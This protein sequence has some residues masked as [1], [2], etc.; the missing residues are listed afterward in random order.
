MFPCCLTEILYPAEVTQQLLCTCDSVGDCSLFKIPL[1]QWN[2]ILNAILGY[3]FTSLGTHKKK[4]LCV[5]CFF[6]ALIHADSAFWDNLP[7][8]FTYLL[9]LIWSSVFNCQSPFLFLLAVICFYFTLHFPLL[10][11]R[12]AF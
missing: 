9:N 8:V 2:S 3:L 6:S 11:S 7:L 12:C 5:F 10:L 4:K 1:N